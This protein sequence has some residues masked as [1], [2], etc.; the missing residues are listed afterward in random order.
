MLLGFDKTAWMAQ[1]N[2][3]KRIATEG[4]RIKTRLDVGRY[5]QRKC[6]GKYLCQKTNKIS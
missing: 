2:K 5:D 1:G 3:R 6:T 4:E